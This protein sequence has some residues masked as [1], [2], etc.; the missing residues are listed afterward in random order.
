MKRIVS[1]ICLL[2]T[3]LL[4]FGCGGAT[5]PAA[6]ESA[7]PTAAESPTAAPTATAAPVP[8][9]PQ[10]DCSTARKP[11]VEAI[12]KLFV[13]DGE[14]EGPEP[15]CSKTHGAWLNLADG[16]ADILFLIAPTQEEKAYLHER[17]VDVEMKV[18]GYDGL[19]FIGNEENPVQNLSADQLRAI[20]RGEITN[21]SEL[22]GVNADIVVYYRNDQSG[23][24]RLFESL[25]WDGYVIPYFDDM[26]FKEGD[27]DPEVEQRSYYVEDDMGEISQK[28]IVDRYAIG[29]NIMSY[30]DSEFADSGLKLF[31]I[32][33]VYPCTETLATAEYPF[34]TTSYCAIRADEAADSPA[35]R[36][37]DWVGSDESRSLIAENSS[38]TVAFT[39]SVFVRSADYVEEAET[40]PLSDF[41][42]ELN[43]RL[44]EKEE[45]KAFTRDELDFIRNGVFALSGKK[46][47]TLKYQ[48]YFD[49]QPWYTGK[50]SPSVNV[51]KYFNA[52]QK[53]NLETILAYVKTL[54]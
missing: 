31:S 25:V 27:V 38:L 29:F 16:A 54:G 51:Q 47:K 43:T 40:T 34:L 35:R 8:Q 11:I 5:D 30:I 50:Y 24:Q 33:G 12:Y 52:Y 37:Y 46:F 14:Y 9:L 23:S 3:V 1:C 48:N 18:Y 42:C 13:T 26:G 53:T 20:Y 4:L 6:K 17:G 15:L 7:A 41:I 49:N 45:L 2:L 32:D 10:I 39:D 22:G 21:W 36:L 28:V 44:I 19:V